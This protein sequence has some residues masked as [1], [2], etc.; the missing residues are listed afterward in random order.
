MSYLVPK[1]LKSFVYSLDGD[2]CGFFLLLSNANTIDVKDQSFKLN[3][4]LIVYSI[5]SLFTTSK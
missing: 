2:V 1:E 4:Y 3:N 5:N